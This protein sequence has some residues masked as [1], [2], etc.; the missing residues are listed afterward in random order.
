MIGGG[1]DDEEKRI[2][3]RYAFQENNSCAYLLTRVACNV[4]YRT[5][6][7]RTIAYKT[8]NHQGVFSPQT[9]GIAG[10]VNRSRILA[11]ARN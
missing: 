6:T 7:T 4:W 10:G 11:H 1:A 2:V 9:T 5:G 3:M 8:T